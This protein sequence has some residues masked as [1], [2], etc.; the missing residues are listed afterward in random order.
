M[1]PSTNH[2]S[3]VFLREFIINQINCAKAGGD[4]RLGDGDRFR[5]IRRDQADE[6]VC[7]ALIRDSVAEFGHAP[8][9]NHFAHPLEA[10]S[11]FRNRDREQGL[12]FFT[13]FR[14]FRDKP[15]SVEVHVCAA[16]DGHQCL[17]R[18]TLL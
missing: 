2:V 4:E 16:G 11:F 10:A 3:D 17:A 15:Q 6:H 14:S 1:A 12:A 5:P 7:L 9:P 13:C 18:Q 8:L